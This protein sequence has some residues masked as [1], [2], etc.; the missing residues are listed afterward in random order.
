MREDGIGAALGHE[1]AD[2]ARRLGGVRADGGDVP[3]VVRGGLQAGEG[4]DA[5]VEDGRHEA[6]VHLVGAA[7]VNVVVCG[8]AAPAEVGTRLGHAR[9]VEGG[10]LRTAGVDG[11]GD[12]VQVDGLHILASSAANVAE[13]DVVAVTRVA[14]LVEIDGLERVGRARHGD[15]GH[16]D[17]GGDIHRA[18]HQTHL[19]RA[20]DVGGE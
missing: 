1:G 6:E 18:R 10:G 9:H 12:V 14:G 15:G 8:I 11:D 19:Q 7:V 5:A 16:L 13:G 17:E 2:G 3:V 4:E 20:Q